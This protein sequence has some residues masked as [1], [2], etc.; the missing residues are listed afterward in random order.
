MAGLCQRHSHCTWP[1][2]CVFLPSHGLCTRTLTT[3]HRA[4]PNAVW[5]HLNLI[6]STKSLYPTQISHRYLELGLQYIFSGHN[7]THNFV[8]ALL[9]LILIFSFSGWPFI[10]WLNTTFILFYSNSILILLSFTH[11]SALSLLRLLI[12]LLQL[13]SNLITY[14][15]NI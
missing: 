2:L 11:I 9:Q 6:T 13:N 4:H 8:L 15:C 14:G 10:I 3:G 12:F 5:P 1:S 7:T